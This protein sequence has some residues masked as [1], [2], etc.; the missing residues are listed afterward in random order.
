MN[1]ISNTFI[2]SRTQVIK[3][4]PSF[5]V[6]EGLIFI[7][8][9]VYSSLKAAWAAETRAMGTRNGEHDT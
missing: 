4:S 2:L 7:Y 6:K 8:N 1:T 5:I 3:I 9:L